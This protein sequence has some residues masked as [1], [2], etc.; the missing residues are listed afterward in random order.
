MKQGRRT[1]DTGESTRDSRGKE[2]KDWHMQEQT[3]Q[4]RS[5]PSDRESKRDEEATRE[6][7]VGG[8][9]TART[10]KDRRWVGE[11]DKVDRRRKI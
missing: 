7:S 10:R 11:K 5:I 1:G 3:G 4:V 9:K 8:R 6:W 2:T